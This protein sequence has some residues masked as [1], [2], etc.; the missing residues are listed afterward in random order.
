MSLRH[1]PSWPCW[2]AAFAGLANRLDAPVVVKAGIAV[3]SFCWSHH[4]VR[5]PPF[6]WEVSRTRTGKGSQWWHWH[7]PR[8]CDPGIERYESVP[9]SRSRENW[10][11]NRHIHRQAEHHGARVLLPYEK[12]PQILLTQYNDFQQAVQLCPRSMTAFPTGCWRWLLPASLSL[13]LS[14]A[15]Q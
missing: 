15:I 14:P 10:L 1:R 13:S 9:R 5:H 4:Q 6:I 11:W 7:C 8:D 2:H 3:P 12:P